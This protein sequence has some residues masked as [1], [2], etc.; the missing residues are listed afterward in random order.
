MRQ[1][2]VG[3]SAES[4]RYVVKGWAY[5][6]EQDWDLTQKPGQNSYVDLGDRVKAG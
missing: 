3:V 6:G 5:T 2:N 4:Q 1:R